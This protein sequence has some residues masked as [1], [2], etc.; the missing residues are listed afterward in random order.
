[1]PTVVKEVVVAVSVAVAALVPVMLTE[2]GMLQVTG[3]EALVGEAVTEQLRF[4]A[5]VKP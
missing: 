4:T 2:V 5:P 3:L 1:V